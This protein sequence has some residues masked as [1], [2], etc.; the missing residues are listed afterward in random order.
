MGLPSLTAELSADLRAYSGVHMQRYSAVFCR[1]F[2]TAAYPYAKAAGESLTGTKAR[3][4][5]LGFVS[6]CRTDQ[7]RLTIDFGLQV[8]VLEPR[9]YC[10]GYCRKR[11]AL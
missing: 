10:T 11:L 9:L 3:I 2:Q 7:R 6:F 4:P 5:D 1:T 8:T